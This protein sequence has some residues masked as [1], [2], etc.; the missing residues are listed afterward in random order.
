MEYAKTTPTKSPAHGLNLTNCIPHQLQ[1]VPHSD[2]YFQCLQHLPPL[3][4]F[5]PCFHLQTQKHVQTN[6]MLSPKNAK[7][8]Y[9]WQITRQ[10]REARSCSIWHDVSSGRA[11]TGM[12]RLKAAFK[13]CC[14]NTIHCHLMRTAKAVSNPGGL[15]KRA[16]SK[17]KQEGSRSTTGFLTCGFL[18]VVPF[19]WRAVT[20][21]VPAPVW[22][23]RCCQTRLRQPGTLPLLL[24]PLADV[25][26]AVLGWGRAGAHLHHSP[27]SYACVV[28]EK[29]RAPDGLTVS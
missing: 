27:P 18:R 6:P 16:G 7:Y 17:C 20:A 22:C 8:S 15:C 26:P 12:Q 28:V 5:L 2:L 19:L 29:W 21:A 14:L 9:A 23:S 1:A 11:T 3:L 13:A 25:A 4:I 10:S 24:L